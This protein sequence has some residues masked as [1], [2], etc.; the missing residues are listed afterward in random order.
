MAHDVVGKTQRL[1]EL[2]METP[3]YKQ[4]TSIKLTSSCPLPSITKEPVTFATQ[5]VQQIGSYIQIDK[6]IC[7]N[8][9][10]VRLSLLNRS[11]RCRAMI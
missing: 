3:W 5:L 8:P 7:T 10:M 11:L 4:K 2:A 9:F 6:S 1:F